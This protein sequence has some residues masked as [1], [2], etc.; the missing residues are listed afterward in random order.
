ML[1]ILSSVSSFVAERCKTRAI[2][3]NNTEVRLASRG[4]QINDADLYKTGATVI[5]LNKTKLLDRKVTVSFVVS[6]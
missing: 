4:R 5:K 2:S 3:R 6:F 1:I